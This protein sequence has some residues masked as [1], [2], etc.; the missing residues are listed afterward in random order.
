MLAQ[1]DH[2]AQDTFFSTVAVDLRADRGRREVEVSAE[3][4]TIRRRLKG[5]DM[6]LSLAV[7]SYRGVALCL[8]PAQDGRL[9]YQV[10]LIHRDSDL[11]VL[12]DE[13]ADD[14]DII[15]DW[16]LW[17]RVLGRPALVE[18]EIGQ[19]ELVSADP[20]AV[21][22]SGA[23]TRRPRPVKRRPRFLARRKAGRWPIQPT[24]HACEREIVART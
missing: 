18:R 2:A 22:R 19:F 23:L 7:S 16:R 13:A 15:A 5:I 6:R 17:A 24:V 21:E 11:S 4:V 1:N 3:R 9:A 20:E 12:L 14:T 8:R 10:R